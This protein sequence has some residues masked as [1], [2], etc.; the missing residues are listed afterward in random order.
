MAS[1]IR[2]ILIITNVNDRKNFETLLGNGT[3]FGIDIKYAS[4]ESLME[5]QRHL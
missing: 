2:D 4:Q 5:L 1:G 3:Q